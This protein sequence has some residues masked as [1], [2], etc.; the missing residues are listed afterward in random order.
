[1][2]DA[3]FPLSREQLAALHIRRPLPPTRTRLIFGGPADALWTGYEHLGAVDMALSDFV[4]PDGV[5]IDGFRATL[6]GEIKR[7][8]NFLPLRRRDIHLS[9]SV[10]PTPPAERERV[11][12]KHMFELA[13]ILF[14][15]WRN[16]LIAAAPADAA[17]SSKAQKRRRLRYNKR[18]RDL[19]APPT[20]D[21][22]L[23][24]E[25]PAPMAREQTADLERAARSVEKYLRAPDQAGG[26]AIIAAQGA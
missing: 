10:V 7:V 12:T 5:R 2:S 15:G 1:M 9:C 25:K 23:S 14:Y 13:D 3:A 26:A 22:I 21:L 16:A 20:V 24:W 4:R 11:A 18:V 8:S 6:A 19:K 17:R